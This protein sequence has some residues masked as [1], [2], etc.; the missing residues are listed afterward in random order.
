MDTNT[1]KSAYSE[2]RNGAN[3]FYK[4]WA[5]E[6]FHYSDGVKACADAGCHW[7]LDIAATELPAVLK[8]K[9]EMLGCLHVSVQDSSAKLYMTGGADKVLWERSVPYTDMPDG[10]WMFYVADELYRRAMILPSEY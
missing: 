5:Q 8:D 4:H 10:E 2:F 6:S 7:L 9:D 1:F 3:E